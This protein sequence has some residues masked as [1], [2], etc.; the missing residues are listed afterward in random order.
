MKKINPLLIIRN[1]ILGTLYILPGFS[2]IVVFTLY[3][4][5]EDSEYLFFPVK[6][7]KYLWVLIKISAGL[8]LWLSLIAGMEKVL[9]FIP[10]SWKIFDEDLET[11]TNIKTLISFFL[12]SY[13][14]YFII[15]LMAKYKN[16]VNKSHNKSIHR[17]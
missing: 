15:N 7:Y 16:T 9:F 14:T 2:V 10:D 8:S 12:G 13:M 1:L 6:K 5:K 3:S 17:T 11:W 4:L